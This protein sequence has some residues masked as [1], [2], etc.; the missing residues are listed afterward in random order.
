[1]TTSCFIG[2]FLSAAT[3]AG[4]ILRDILTMGA[5]PGNDLLSGPV[6]VF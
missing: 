4:G 2:P 3:G 1:L 6:L 5:M